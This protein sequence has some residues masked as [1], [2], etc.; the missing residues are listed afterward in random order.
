MST[1]TEN[2]ETSSKTIPGQPTRMRRYVAAFVPPVILGAAVIG[3]WYYIT[4]GVL[5][6]KRRFLLRPIHSV[7]D[8]GFLDGDN[9]SESLNALW[10]STE[11][12]LIGL[13]ISIGL[14]F[15]LAIVLYSKLK[16]HQY[17]H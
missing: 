8:V 9:R 16:I 1:V 17:H 11:V 6:E 14:G 10:S 4:F 5:A 15:V 13:S 3:L 2:E 7:I 12:A